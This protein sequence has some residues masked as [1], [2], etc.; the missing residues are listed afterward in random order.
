MKR[1]TY[2]VY[3]NGEYIADYRTLRG[4]LNYIERRKL[5]Y[6]YDNDLGIIDNEGNEY[7]PYTGKMMNESINEWNMWDGDK[8]SSYPRQTRLIDVADRKRREQMLD[9]KERYNNDPEYHEHIKRLENELRRTDDPQHAE[10]LERRIS[11]LKS[12]VEGVKLSRTSRTIRE[13]LS[14]RYKTHNKINES[15]ST[16][17]TEYIGGKFLIDETNFN[18]L[19]MFS[20]VNVSNADWEELKQEYG[21]SSSMTFEK[22]DR[23][24]WKLISVFIP[25]PIGKPNRSVNVSDG[26]EVSIREILKHNVY[27]VSGKTY[28]YNDIYVAI[29]LHRPD[30]D[31]NVLYM[32]KGSDNFKYDERVTLIKLLKSHD[33]NNDALFKFSTIREDDTIIINICLDNG[34][35]Y[36]LKCNVDEIDEILKTHSKRVFRNNFNTYF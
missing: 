18:N 20:H 23:D 13:S 1:K 9:R 31:M 3:L 11:K 6:N 5:E 35:K 24:V 16:K 17:D 33:K 22:V 19:P 7:H 25:G 14:K 36:Y 15:I 12:L 21:Y 2:W 26:V 30:G 4:C 28:E 29:P 32:Y 10:Y 27:K 8:R 34:S